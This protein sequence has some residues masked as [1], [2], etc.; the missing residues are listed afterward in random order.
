[1]ED[2]ERRLGPYRLLDQIGRGSFGVVWLAEKQSSIT[3]TRFALKLPR[4]EDIDFD[5]FKREADIWV[6]ASGHPNVLPLIDADVY[7][8]QA[9]IVSEYAPDG[10]LEDWRARHGGRA[11]SAE[12]A[13]EIIEGVLAGLDHLH[14][15][16]IIHRDLKPDNILLQRDT[17]RLTDF[18]ISRVLRSSSHFTKNISGT[19]VYMAPEAFDGKRDERTDIWAVGVILYELLA[20]RLPYD[21]Q[22]TTSLIG[23]IVRHDPPPLPEGLVPEALRRVVMKALER[24]PTK[25]YA[26]AAEMRRDLREAGHRLWLE[27]HEASRRVPETRVAG[28]AKAH[29]PETRLAG[30]VKA[31]EPVL[32]LAEK[33]SVWPRTLI[34]GIVGLISGVISTYTLFISGIGYYAPGVVFG[35]AVYLFGE[36]SSSPPAGR[37]KQIFRF[38]VVVVASTVGWRLAITLK[39]SNSAFG[40]LDAG[41]TGGM[42]IVL[43][44]LLCWNFKFQR[45]LYALCVVSVAGLSGFVI[46]LLVGTNLLGIFTIWQT[47]VLTSHAIAFGKDKKWLIISVSVLALIA[48]AALTVDTFGRSD[49]SSSQTGGNQTQA[50]T[51]NTA[52]VSLTNTQAATPTPTAAQPTSKIVMRFIWSGA[53]FSAPIQRG[54]VGV[55][56]GGQTFQKK[57][58][59][60][61]WFVLDGVPCNQNAK[62]A[63]GRGGLISRT[64]GETPFHTDADNN[65]EVTRYVA[66]SDKP[67]ALG[68]F[69]WEHGDFISDDMDNI[70]ACFTCQ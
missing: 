60:R 67:V 28:D 23:A 56:A 33:T 57:T 47:L 18:G 36:Y 64:Q 68:A 70:D 3:T 1:M 5:A 32:A 62:I 17:P 53:D 22:D 38:I 49:S 54:D 35:I 6:Q 69:S 2:H 44:E 4:D 20:G 51:T 43:A 37:R 42:C 15:R 40:F 66:C 34:W 65:L 48:G 29:V 16:R 61:G 31:A 63:F 58:S 21:Q 10:S 14:G 45:W 52:N 12:A 11:P 46:Y 9:V 24:D 59:S 26:S 30:D 19:F 50:A 41:V 8:G 55:T 25:R 13:C 39:P 27:R 7:D